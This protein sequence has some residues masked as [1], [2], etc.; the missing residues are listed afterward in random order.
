MSKFLP[1]KYAPP[2]YK[3]APLTVHDLI[4]QQVNFEDRFISHVVYDPQD[5]AVMSKELPDTRSDAM[6]RHMWGHQITR[7]MHSLI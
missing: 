3:G 1:T 4:L 5:P 7:F 6:V 2:A